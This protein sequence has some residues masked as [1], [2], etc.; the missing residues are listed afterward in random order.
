MPV[1]SHY[2]FCIF[3][4]KVKQGHIARVKCLS[5]LTDSYTCVVKSTIA[6]PQTKLSH[7]GYVISDNHFDVI[8]HK[9]TVCG[10]LYSSSSDDNSLIIESPVYIQPH[11]QRQFN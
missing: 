6:V 11:Q 1:Q 8:N 7:M 4:Y 2:F 9:L 10:P 5:F 3:C